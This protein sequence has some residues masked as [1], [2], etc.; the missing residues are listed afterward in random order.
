VNGIWTPIKK[1]ATSRG[2]PWFLVSL[3]IVVAVLHELLQW[4]LNVSLSPVGQAALWLSVLIGLGLAYLVYGHFEKISRQEAELRIRLSETERLV[5]EAYQRLDSIFQISQEFVE[6]SDENEVVKSILSLLVD[7]TEAHGAAFVPLDEHGQPQ[8]AL[9]HGDMPDSIMETWSEYLASK[10]VRQRCLQCRFL[11]NP[12]KP[13]ECP[14]LTGPFAH[15]SGLLCLPVRRGERDFGVA[16]LFLSN[17]ERLDA[18]AR[19]FLRALMDETALGLEGIRLRRRELAALRQMQVLRQKTDLTGLL[20]SLLDNVHKTLDANFA[21]MMVP[22]RG[23]YRSKIDL[24]LGD[25]PS[26]VRPFVD[27]I[28]QG[29]MTSGEPVLL[30]EVSGD[31][32]STPGLRSLVAAPLVT[33]EGLVMGAILVGNRKA[34]GFHQRQLALLQTIAG[35]VAL[36]VQNASLM[37]ELEYKVM[38]Q[39]RARLAR[40]IHDGLA[41][42]IGFLKLQA[43][44]LRKHLIEG[45][46]E[47]AL[48]EVDLFYTTIGGAYQDARQAIDGLRISPDEYSLSGW[49]AQIASEFQEISG[50]SVDLEEVNMHTHLS[51]EIH[52]QLIRIFQEALSNVRK[53]AQANNVWMACRETDNDLVLEIRDDGKGFSPEDVTSASQYGLRGMRERADLIGADFQVISQPQAGTIVRLRLPVNGFKEVVT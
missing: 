39:E 42:T 12:G 41:Q 16:S 28:L 51:P 26:K 8:T 35:Q 15:A 29:I 24:I 27:A 44:Q 38:L 17:P 37:S 9:S 52:A 23:E 25:F 47:R 5:D 43:G 13:E 40:E 34:R 19:S 48:E 30:G 53:H 20:N 11:D 4:F 1:F 6:A 22:S 10:E 3:V 31:S 7:L 18:R 49:L 2:L 21:I 45:N 46:V 50:L 33:T 36:V 14:L 32:D